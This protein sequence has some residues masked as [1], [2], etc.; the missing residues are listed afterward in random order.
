M[1][2][3]SLPWILLAALAT[4]QAIVALVLLSWAAPL[5][6]DPPLLGN[7]VAIRAQELQDLVAAP[8]SSPRLKGIGEQYHWLFWRHGEGMEGA[9]LA[10]AALGTNLDRAPAS[11]ESTAFGDSQGARLTGRQVRSGSVAPVCQKPF[12]YPTCKFA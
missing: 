3:F 2:K 9:L 6:F 7:G 8:G 5:F 11:A 12:I 4:V 1:S 10:S